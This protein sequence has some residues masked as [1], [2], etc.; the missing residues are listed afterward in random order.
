[1]GAQ[2]KWD[3]GVWGKLY[4]GSLLSM[5]FMLAHYGEKAHLRPFELNCSRDQVLYGIE[6]KQNTSHVHPQQT[7]DLRTDG[8][9]KFHPR[10]IHNVSHGNRDVMWVIWIG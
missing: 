4:T 5:H 1:M 7:T 2:S 3:G 6:K 10:F 9:D 8:Q